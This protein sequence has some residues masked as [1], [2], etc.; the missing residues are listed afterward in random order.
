[1]N[2]IMMKMIEQIVMQVSNAKQKFMIKILKM[3]EAY[4]Q[5]VNL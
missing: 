4:I 1:M 5:Q 3:L 2:K